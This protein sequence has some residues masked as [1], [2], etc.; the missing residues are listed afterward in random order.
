MCRISAINSTSGILIVFSSDIMTILPK[1]L[2]KHE[3]HFEGSMSVFGGVKKYKTTNADWFNSGQC[4]DPICSEATVRT[5][6]FI[7]NCDA[8]LGQFDL[9]DTFSHYFD[10]FLLCWC[11]TFY[12]GVRVT[13]LRYDAWSQWDCLNMMDLEKSKYLNAWL[14][15]TY[16]S[17][18]KIDVNSD[19]ICSSNELTRGH[20]KKTISNPHSQQRSLRFIRLC[21]W[22]PTI[23]FFSSQLHQDCSWSSHQAHWEQEICSSDFCY[24]ICW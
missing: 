9:E 18:T 24:Q 4:Q 12:P 17:Q 2:W 5:L 11:F 15:W 3:H 21:F 7:Q 14:T 13:H 22:I 16:G 23:V 10:L 20:G 6:N 8:T 1:N 19:Q